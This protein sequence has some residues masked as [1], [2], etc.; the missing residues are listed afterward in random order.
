MVRV[1]AELE[2]IIS[3]H[4]GLRRLR[5]D[6]R[7]SEVAERLGE[8][9]PLEEIL[10]SILKSSP[11]LASLFLSGRRL[12]QPHRRRL[13]GNGHSGPNGSDEG[14]GEFVGKPHPSYFRFRQRRDGDL[15]ERNV[16]LG[17]RCRLRFETD[18]ANDYFIRANFPGKY[19]AEIVEGPAGGVD[20][21]HSLTLHDGIANWS[22]ELPDHLEVGNQITIQCSV[23]D[24]VIGE[25]MVNL[26]RL[27]I[28]PQTSRQSGGNGHRQSR[29]GNG[30]RNGG[31][32][33]SGLELP[34]IIRVR[35]PEYREHDFNKYSACK[36][37]QAVQEDGGEERTT[38][39]FFINIDNLYL[40]TEMK[41][42][43]D[44]P[45][46]L[47]AKYIYGNVLI[48]LAL[49]QDHLGS[50]R[51]TN[52]GGNR[53]DERENGDGISIEERVAHCTRAL[54]PFILPM[55]N[56]LGALSEDDVTTLGQVG[57]EE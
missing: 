36:I 34:K 11:T 45:V 19:H 56:Y 52:A 3:R 47:Q 41:Y 33:P 8:S 15:L 28:K 46:L 54:G 48:G 53:P 17:R 57:D 37:Q 10:Q 14:Q 13:N 40:R 31:T 39:D 4:P 35:E 22:V 16:E 44:N 20:I 21:N 38:Y 9:K 2:E 55:I 5:D 18:V 26:A 1:E 29:K 49:I 7:N 24:E 23:S 30:S 43:R 25:P 50:E 27:R 51:Q 32:L 42:R 12:S 6:R